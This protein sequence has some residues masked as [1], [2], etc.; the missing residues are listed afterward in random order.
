M[1]IFLSGDQAVPIIIAKRFVKKE[2]KLI[3]RR[4][5]VGFK[6]GLGTMIY[7]TIELF[8]ECFWD[9]EQEVLDAGDSSVVHYVIDVSDDPGSG[10][11]ELVVTKLDGKAHPG[12]GVYCEVISPHPLNEDYDAGE[13]PH[14]PTQEESSARMVQP[15]KRRPDHTGPLP[16][17]QI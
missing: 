2:P 11:P 15:K 4:R 10:A 5:F 16:P 3:K 6:Q 17:P 8:Q 13:T 9:V 12:C 14:A 1:E 7:K